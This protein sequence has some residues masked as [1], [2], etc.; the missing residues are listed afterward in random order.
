MVIGFW[1]S[2]FGALTQSNFSNLGASNLYHWS[3]LVWGNLMWEFPLAQVQCDGF[4]IWTD[5]VRKNLHHGLWQQIIFIG[6]G[7]WGFASGNSSAVQDRRRAQSWDWIPC[8]PSYSGQSYLENL[9]SLSHK[10]CCI[11]S[12]L[13]SVTFF[14][15]WR[16][17]LSF[18]VP[19]L[20]HWACLNGASRLKWIMDAF[21][22]QVCIC[23]DL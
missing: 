15:W 20:L 17:R 13:G 2:I 4:G 16:L 12:M 19:M 22:G 1:L 7:A 10:L 18:L 8:I 3:G 23:W 14:A 5:R 6:R 21:A 9:L 11:W